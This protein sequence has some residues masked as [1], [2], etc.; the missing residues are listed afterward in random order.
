MKKKMMALLLTLMMAISGSS[1]VY[2]GTGYIGTSPR[3]TVSVGRIME[4]ARASASRA[5]IE[6]SGKFVNLV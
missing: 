2:A 4:Q 1:L 5:A 3:V 6:L